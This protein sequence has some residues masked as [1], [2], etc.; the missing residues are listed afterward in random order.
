M[1]LTGGNIGFTGYQQPNYAGAV[2][3]AGLPMQAIG[4]AVGQA[5]DYFKQQGE[6]KKLIKQSDIQIDAALKLFPD[7]A[8]T[9]QGVRDQIKDENVSLN[10]RADIAESVAGLI[11]M[12][13]KQ[14]QA[15]AEFGLKKRQL[16]IEEGQGI[17]SALI[18]RAELEAKA[19]EPIKLK[20]RTIILGP[21]SAADVLGDDYG[22]IYDPQSKL[23]IVDFNGYVAGKSLEETTMPDD[24]N[25]LPPLPQYGGNI[26]TDTGEVL[27]DLAPEL[28]AQQQA[29]VDAGGAAYPDGVAV[30]GT[31]LPDGAAPVGAETPVSQTIN[32][33]S[34]PT[35]TPIP[36]PRDPVAIQ[37]AVDLTS[38]GATSGLTPRS[39]KVN[40]EPLVRVN[41]GDDPQQQRETAIDKSLLE[42]KAGA[43]QVASQ[44]SKIEEISKLLDEGVNTGFAQNV[45]MQ[46]KR[47]FGQDVSDQEAFKAASGN[48]ALGFINLTKGAISDREMQYFTEVLAPSIGTSVE[49]NKKIVE[50][51][52]KAADKAAKV[53]GIISSG[54]RSGKSAFDIDEEV[55]KFRNTEAIGPKEV[56]GMN[57]IYSKHGVQ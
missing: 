22:N 13:T 50:F 32:E 19:N 56:G 3:A 53:E 27:P 38:G 15:N 20:P 18:K 29:V 52:R 51:L 14:M 5:A 46:G 49:G 45:L 6:K 4:Q 30:A 31:P 54:M 9:L 47:I 1:A 21:D 7:L 39:R 44:L 10:E 48:V 37:K 43:A 24:T 11:N 36:Q 17:Q 25:G 57:E 55:Q 8:P 23:R 40:R 42:T 12:G 2:E 34:G 33:L 16:D 28:S 41:T 35:Y 26:P